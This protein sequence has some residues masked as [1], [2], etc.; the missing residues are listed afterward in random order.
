MM[1]LPMPLPSG[2]DMPN[3]Q[4]PV[5]LNSWCS[6]QMVQT[7]CYIS[8]IQ[9]SFRHY[10][11][12]HF[13]LEKPGRPK[14]VPDILAGRNRLKVTFVTE[15]FVHVT[16]R[17]FHAVSIANLYNIFMIEGVELSKVCLSKLMIFFMTFYCS[18]ANLVPRWNRT[19]SVQLLGPVTGVIC[20]DHIS[21][22]NS[23]ACHW[24]LFTYEKHLTIKCQTEDWTEIYR[25]YL[26][27]T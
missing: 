25:L 23:M 24:C 8:L 27:I 15:H 7:A 14:E 6:S 3:W 26:D 12:W 1:F 11:K 22:T 10:T 4:C 2:K 17:W 20:T 13:D 18:C 9:A 19:F 16:D 21:A 5:K